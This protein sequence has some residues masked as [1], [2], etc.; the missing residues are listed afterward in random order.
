MNTVRWNL[1][2]PVIL[3]VSFLVFTA[4]HARGQNV[5][6]D[7]LLMDA[8]SGIENQQGELLGAQKYAIFANRTHRSKPDKKQMK[9]KSP[10][11]E[12]KYKNYTSDDDNL[13]CMKCGLS[14]TERGGR[15]VNGDVVKPLYKY[16]WIVPLIQMNQMKCG[17]AIISRKFILTAAHCVFNPEKLKYPECRGD[18]APKKCYY[19]A[20]QFTI[21]L[22]GRQKLK[23]AMRV[24]RIIPHQEFD[25]ER[26][27]NDIALLELEEPLKC[28]GKTS[29]ICLPTKKEMYKNGQELYVAGWGKN[30]PDRLSKYHN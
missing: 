21:K 28:T 23:R 1:C 17:G 4:V 27:L 10:E 13:D 5:H 25:Y 8:D 18:R 26:H 2:I 6:L 7:Y 19:K 29:P 3:V 24:K 30:T 16:P 12:D 20:N 15:V 9:R 11:T 14:M 22:L